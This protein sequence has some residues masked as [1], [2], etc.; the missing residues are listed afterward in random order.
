MLR[1]DLRRGPRLLEKG[2]LRDLGDPRA[3]PPWSRL[4]HVRLRRLRGLILAPRLEAGNLVESERDRLRGA[5]GLRL[6]RAEA[7]GPRGEYAAQVRGA[8]KLVQ[9]VVVLAQLHELEVVVPLRLRPEKVD[10]L[11]D[12]VGGDPP[13]ARLEDLLDQH[14]VVA[15]TDV[16]PVDGTVLLR[17]DTHENLIREVQQGVELAVRAVLDLKLEV[18]LPVESL[19]LLGLE[20]QAEPA[21]E[22]TLRR[23]FALQDPQPLA[24]PLEG[25][26]QLALELLLEGPLL[27]QVPLLVLLEDLLLDFD[28][29]LD[30]ALDSVELGGLL[31]EEL[32]VA[33]PLLLVLEDGRVVDAG[34]DVARPRLVEL[35]GDDRPP[36]IQGL[37]GGRALLEEEGWRFP[38]LL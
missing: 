6:Q 24:L 14:L 13:P 23:V 3:E 31:L 26:P 35:K 36:L 27:L 1:L 25:L 38:R 11:V 30:L 20:E 22:P 37:L 10:A 17:R 8:L 4:E 9:V 19:Q 32:S 33:H 28:L 29:R 34:E 18:S 5:G 15:A 2:P 7:R 21:A 12:L 16:V